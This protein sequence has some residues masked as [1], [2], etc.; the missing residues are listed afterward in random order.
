[1]A[2]V[3]NIASPGLQSVAC[4][5]GKRAQNL[6]MGGKG[7]TICPW[8]HIGEWGRERGKVSGMDVGDPDPMKSHRPETVSFSA[9]N[10]QRRQQRKSRLISSR[11][12]YLYQGWV[13]FQ[14][15][16]PA[17]LSIKALPFPSSVRPKSSEQAQRPSRFPLIL[18]PLPTN[19]PG[20]FRVSSPLPK[21]EK[22]SRAS[23]VGSPRPSQEPNMS[24]LCSDLRNST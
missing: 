7:Y 10:I 23:S 4:L 3:D 5:G 13:Q 6:R 9:R 22:K 18:A 15:E 20:K 12:V 21:E 16:V 14:Y 2:D 19:K 17:T 8:F 11:H 24:Y 1:M